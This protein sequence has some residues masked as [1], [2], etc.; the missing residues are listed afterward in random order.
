MF[1][2]VKSVGGELVLAA[3]VPFAF[4]AAALFIRSPARSRLLHSEGIASALSLALTLGFGSIW[5][6]A[7]RSLLQAHMTL[8]QAAL[9]PVA[10]SALGTIAAWMVAKT[11]LRRSGIGRMPLPPTSLPAH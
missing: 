5:A 2:V 3:L 6:T 10:L 8:G 11:V 4:M 7:M 9:I 1:S